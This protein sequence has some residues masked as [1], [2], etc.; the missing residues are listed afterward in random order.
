MWSGAD[1][2]GLHPLYIPPISP[3]YPLRIPLYIPPIMGIGGEWWGPVGTTS[4]LDP[5]YIPSISLVNSTYIRSISPVHPLYNGDRWGLGGDGWAA[6]T[7]T[8]PSAPGDE[9]RGR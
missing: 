2:W 9:G 8:P 6:M 4:P 1:W 5:F 3:L 7:A